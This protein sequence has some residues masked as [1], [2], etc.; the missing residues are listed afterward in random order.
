MQHQV[1]LEAPIGVTR[2]AVVADE[3]ALVVVWY[4]AR[5]WFR[6]ESRQQ[7]VASQAA[8]GLSMMYVNSEKE[9]EAQ[10]ELQ[11]RDLCAHTAV[12]HHM[13]GLLLYCL[14]FR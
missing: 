14:L 13:D 11:K 5:C 4:L 6:C 10:Q 7:P 1:G 12:A 8:Y 3:A 9:E 2:V